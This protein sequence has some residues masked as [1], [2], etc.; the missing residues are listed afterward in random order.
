MGYHPRIESESYA[1]F[2]TTRCVQSRLWFVNNPL[3][4][5]A[6]LGYLA[7]FA[8]RYAVIL[9]AF[10]IEG[11]HTHGPAHF[12]QMNRGD[13]M[14]DLNSCIARAVPRYTPEHGGG[15]LWERRYSGEFLP[16]DEDIENQFFY[17][18]LQPVQDGLVEKISLYP[19]Y[20]C[21]HDA[22]YGITRKF[23][24]MNWADYNAAVRRGKKV[25][26]KDY[27]VTVELKYARLPGYEHLT[28]KDYAKMML[29]KLE[30]RRVAI[31]EKRRAAGLG[32][33]GCEKL[34]QTKPGSLPRSTKRSTMNSHRPRVLSVCPIRRAECK[35]W[36]FD[37][38][39]RYKEASYEYRHGRFD[40]EFPFGTY[41]PSR[42]AL[43]H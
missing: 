27:V 34:L 29:E 38:Y 23:K 20:N 39:F 40:A 43:R 18:V 12:P 24:V 6:I 11:N 17:T 5:E 15:R 37:I 13:F 35:A 32:F 16:G 19:G 10:S 41:P 3:L 14:R 21:F 2:L 25:Y 26:M 42:T 36:Y 9:Y 1:S 22:I 31:V 28:Q 30:E 4:E 7:K 8:A 33:V